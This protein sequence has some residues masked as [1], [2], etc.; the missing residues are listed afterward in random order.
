M[1]A[2]LGRAAIV[3]A[4]IAMLSGCA[5][6]S[7]AAGPAA[8]SPSQTPTPTPTAACPAIEGVELPP[9]CAPYDPEEAMA[10]NDRHRQ[11]MPLDEV[12]KTSNTEIAGALRGE[13]EGLLSQE[14]ATV[15]G[16]AQVLEAGGLEAPQVREDYGRILFGAS[17]PSGGCVFGEVTEGGVSIEAGGYILDGG[18]LP[19]Q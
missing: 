9:E 7:P 17:G 16:V 13:L 3:L 10:A 4:A 14:N 15:E 1:M 8:P 19:A 11:R 5:S 2:R 6:A 18:C 12:A